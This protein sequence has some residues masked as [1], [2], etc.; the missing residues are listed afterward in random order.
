VKFRSLSVRTFITGTSAIA[1]LF[2]GLAVSR[3]ASAQTTAAQQPAGQQ[4]AAGQQGA[5]QKNYKDRGEYDLYSQITQTQDAKKRLDLLN[6]WQTKYPQS[7]FAQDRLQYFVATLGQLAPSDPN[8]R[9]Q[10]I[11]K[12]TELLKLDPKNFTA[13]YYI[14]PEKT[15]GLPIGGMRVSG[16][17]GVVV[18]PRVLTAEIEGL[19]RRGVDHDLAARTAGS[20]HGPWRM[21]LTAAMHIALPTAFFTAL[22]L[23]SLVVRAT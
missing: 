14:A 19:R 21:A 16:G 8:V 3:S 23:P 4:P 5:P 15:G 1:L 22:G 10:L 7:D 6:Q 12:C 11:D 20:G 18:D 17:N 2:A 13:S 9:Q